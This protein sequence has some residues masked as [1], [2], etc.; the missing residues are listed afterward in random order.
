MAAAKAWGIS[1]DTVRIAPGFVFDKSDSSRSISTQEAM[2]LAEADGGLLGDTGAYWTRK[3]GAD[4]RGG[5]IGASP[6]YST[7]AHVVEVDVDPTTGILRVEKVW[8]AH[9]CGRAINPVM[10]EGQIE[11]SVYMGWAEALMEAQVFDERGLHKGPNLLDYRIPTSMETPDIVASIIETIDPGGPY[12][13]KEAGEGPL[14]PVIPA[15]ANAVY[16]ALGIRLRRI[17]FTPERILAELA[18]QESR[19]AGK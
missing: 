14:H 15:I 12:G 19:L 1:P 3:V 4:Y 13:A 5:T 10:V 6:A 7:T 2:I 16:D 18:A 17:P 8:A 11:G 9:D